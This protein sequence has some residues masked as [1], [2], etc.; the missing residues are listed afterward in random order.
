MG[1]RE[2]GV[3]IIGPNLNGLGLKIQWIELL[4]PNI[5]WHRTIA[6]SQYKNFQ[7]VTSLFVDP[8]MCYNGSLKDMCIGGTKKFIQEPNYSIDTLMK[9][10]TTVSKHTPTQ[11]T[12]THTC[13]VWKKFK[14]LVF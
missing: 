2:R 9:S 4:G 7:M 5:I 6:Y 3:Q 10:F 11:I 8:Y 12:N 13:G 1:N 14:F